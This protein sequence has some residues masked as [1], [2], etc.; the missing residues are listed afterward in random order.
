MERRK[1]LTEVSL[2]FALAC[3]VGLAACSK[4]GDSDNNPGGGGGGTTN[5]KLTVNLATSL[6]NPGDFMISGGVIL[7]RLAAGNTPAS[8][9]A[10][11]STC[12]HQGCT[13]STYNNTSSQIECNAPCG[14][15]SRYSNTGAVVTGPATAAL[16]KYT[17]E[18]NGTTLT[19]K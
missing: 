9:S 5:P 16:S 2:T 14:H 4:G 15:G 3:A 7:I 1:F 13:L 10:L 17:I 6:A 8:F 11:T 18:V 19:V 12:T